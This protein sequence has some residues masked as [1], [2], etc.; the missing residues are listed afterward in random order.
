MCALVTGV[1]TCALPIFKVCFTYS[2]NAQDSPAGKAPP[3]GDQIYTDLQTYFHWLAKGAPTD[4]KLKGA[5]FIKLK[6][7]KLGYDPGR[8]AQVFQQNCASCHGADGTGQR[9]I[10]GRVVFPPFWG[11]PSYTWGARRAAVNNAAA[12]ATKYMP[13]G[14]THR[15]PDPQ[16]W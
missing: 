14:P 7:T 12:F 5:G 1:Q 4:T 8:G 2:M 15:L 6:E 11:Q 16:P 9:D 10:N 13:S 3:L